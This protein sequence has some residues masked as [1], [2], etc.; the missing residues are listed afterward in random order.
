MTGTMILES[1]STGLTWDDTHGIKTGAVEVEN[2][3]GHVTHAAG[4][5]STIAGEGGKRRAEKGEGSEGEA[6]HESDCVALTA[7][8]DPVPQKHAPCTLQRS[9]AATQGRG[10]KGK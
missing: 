3:T 6:L 8:M 7:A 5:R 10:P 1:V 2:A 4:H 9:N